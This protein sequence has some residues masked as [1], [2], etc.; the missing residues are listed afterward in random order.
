MVRQGISPPYL[1]IVRM[2]KAAGIFEKYGLKQ[3]CLDDVK[4]ALRLYCKETENLN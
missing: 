2:L 4:L 1:P 3:W